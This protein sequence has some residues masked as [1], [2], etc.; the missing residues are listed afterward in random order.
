MIESKRER[1]RTHTTTFHVR[2]HHFTR[3]TRFSKDGI[4]GDISRDS[5]F[6]LEILTN[7]TCTF[8]D[9]LQGLGID[10]LN[11]T[12]SI[13]TFRDKTTT[14]WILPCFKLVDKTL[15]GVNFKSIFSLR[16]IYEKTRFH[17][18][19][20]NQSSILDPSM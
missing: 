14:K 17:F 19:I 3:N 7:S 18:I 15:Y 1:E 10:E 4:I 6:T 12:Y 20:L 9:F 11:E 13:R 2:I 16:R 8:E 5:D